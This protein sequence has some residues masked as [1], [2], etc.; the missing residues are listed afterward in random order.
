MTYQPLQRPSKHE[1]GKGMKAKRFYK[2]KMENIKKKFRDIFRF[3]TIV[4]RTPSSNNKKN[5]IIFS[6]Q[7]CDSP[8]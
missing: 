8:H 4:Q 7:S 2:L 6:I 1:T 5:I 3:L